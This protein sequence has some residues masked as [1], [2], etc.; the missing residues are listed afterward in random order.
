MAIDSE[1]Y[2][3]IFTAIYSIMTTIFKYKNGGDVGSILK[4]LQFSTERT[5]D[6]LKFIEHQKD[7]L[8]KRYIEIKLKQTS[9]NRHSYQYRINM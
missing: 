8:S 6:L 4:D 2:Y 5:R 1:T 7:S 9:I 3:E